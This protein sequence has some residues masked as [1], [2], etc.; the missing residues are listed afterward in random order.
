VSAKFACIAAHRPQYEVV[1]MCRVL[2]VS[3]SGFY[4]AQR[5]GPSAH[6]RRD[7]Q[8]LV[9][10]RTAHQ[11]S[12]RRY[13]APRVHV[14]LTH[15]GER[16]GKKRV[17]RLMQRDGLRGRRARRFVHTT[18]SIHGDPIAP[19]TLAR[20]FD[21][22]TV[23]APDRVWASDIT[24][25]PTREGW[26]YLAVILDLATRRVVGWAIRRTL[27]RELAVAALQ[28]ALLHRR[29]P[30]GV[31]HHSDRG[32][33]YAS[34]E[35]RAALTAHGLTASMSRRG[36]CWDN[37]VAESFFATLKVELVY[38]TDW[39]TRD[40]ACRDI[41]EFIEV[42]YNRERRHSSLGYCTPVEYEE[43]NFQHHGTINRRKAA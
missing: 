8:L 29:P 40:A 1:L 14:A 13:G 26:L 12:R 33:Q 28:M 4:A 32:T 17:A 27:D 35:Y 38:E 41:F 22:H 16:V 9:Q 2:A 11:Q 37:A 23:P 19:N 10:I 18:D 6:A 24:Y 42:W 15:D 31:L 20:Q 43:R 39:V 21:V 34:T 36:N 25:V 5:R 7:E 30:R 3:A